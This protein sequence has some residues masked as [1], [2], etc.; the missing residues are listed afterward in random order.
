[1]PTARNYRIA[2][3]RALADG[4]L[5][6]RWPLTYEHGTA[7]GRSRLTS[8]TECAGDGVCKPPTTFDWIEGELAMDD[9]LYGQW[10][11]DGAGYPYMT[12]NA[13]DGA[14]WV[15]ADTRLDA[16]GDGMTDM[17]AAVGDIQK[18][19]PEGRGWELWLSQPHA[20]FP[21]DQA[22][23]CGGNYQED[24]FC[25]PGNVFIQEGP[26]SQPI[27]VDQPVLLGRPVSPMFSL[28]YDGDGRDDAITP[29]SA[30]LEAIDVNAIGYL[31]ISRFTQ[32][33]V[34]EESKIRIGTHDRPAWLYVATD[35]DGDRLGDLLW[36]S[37]NDDAETLDRIGTWKLLVN[38]PGFG[39]P[40]ES[41]DAAT[42]TG[43]RCDT[44]D[45]LHVL[46][47]DG[48]GLTSLLV[49]PTFS[50][51]TQSHVP[52]SQ[53]GNYQALTIG[54]DLDTF[55]WADTGLP[56]DLVQRWK[57]SFYSS[58]VGDDFPYEGASL[59]LDRVVDVQGD[60]LPDIIRYQL[61][62]GDTGEHLDA[63]TAQ[64]LT[65]NPLDEQ[66]GLRVWIND[67]RRFHDGGWL[68]IG[69]PGHALAQAFLA[70]ATLDW[71]GDG[72][73]DLLLPR[74]SD[75][76]WTVW[77]ADHTGVFAEHELPGSPH[78]SVG[79]QRP[80][81]LTSMDV[82]GDGLHDPVFWDPAYDQFWDIHRHRGEQPDR[83]HTIV[84]GLGQ[85]IEI[86]Y[87]SITDY[88]WSD[89]HEAGVCSYP[90][91]CSVR[92]R[93][94]VERHRLDRGLAQ[95]GMRTFRH[96]Y[97][98]ARSDRLE[99]RGLGFSRHDEFELAEHDGELVEVA[100]RS[101][102]FGNLSAYYDEQLLAHPLAGMPTLIVEQRRDLESGLRQASMTSVQHEVMPT[103]ES[104][105][106]ALADFT[107]ARTWEFSGGCFQ[108]FCEIE[109]LQAI[110]PLTER[111]HIVYARDELGFP[112]HERTTFEGEA[113]DMQRSVFHEQ[114]AWLVGLVTEETTTSIRAGETLARTAEFTYDLDTGALTSAIDEP[115]DPEFFLATGIFYDAFGNAIEV[116]V[117]DAQ[118]ELRGGTLQYD[119]RGRYPITQT[120]GLGHS[121]TMLWHEG[122]DVP[123]GMID[124]NGIRHVLDVDGFARTTGIRAFAGLVPR[125]DDGSIAYLPS[126]EPALGGMRIRTEAA[127]HGVRET[128][129]D[130]LARPVRE[131]WVGPEGK[132]RYADITYDDRGRVAS[133]S[134]PAF[135]GEPP[136]DPTSGP[137]TASTA[138]SCT[139]S[140]T[141]ASSA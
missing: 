65:E 50:D 73:L 100:E 40:A 59:S 51:E 92:P 10:S 52:S 2:E 37:P 8:V 109:E 90:A 79:T 77:M 138:R 49:V 71:N 128:V 22:K 38:Q 53:W 110:E 17:F 44:H 23:P 89:L 136:S 102:Y 14:I 103:S 120:N 126:Q 31:L 141:A 9:M 62:V 3:I 41:I 33:G 64:V 72:R 32:D 47:H 55:A 13:Y 106:R 93:Q 30:G 137:T 60:G 5:I 45:K 46:D 61:L 119:D 129:Y 84:D 115:D 68:V 6:R 81:A 125:G 140:R 107:H 15:L 56:P 80:R 105:Y 63:I 28:D 74:D 36:C 108:A 12:D 135:L 75:D 21:D 127:G 27:S 76:S 101:V 117:I 20:K 66:G 18:P 139:T 78:W 43:L 24:D 54:P 131:Y 4:E 82:D 121:T 48:D 69:E 86:E 122:L 42:D 16:N 83:I 98:G 11:W 34:L 97:A 1:M 130:R 133:T 88:E 99:G 124:P 123:S 67:G 35:V 58:F 132:E 85:R 29:S 114:D 118:G 91:D 111:T 19:A 104:S 96:E 95:P 70:A 134:L 116:L 25:V 112:I 39:F 57:P 94:V 113:I 87:R 7:T 26:R